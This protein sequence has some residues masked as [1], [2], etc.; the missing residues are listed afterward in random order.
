VKRRGE[1]LPT[2]HLKAGEIY[3]TDQP[4]VVVTV[5]G[6]CLSVVLH[7]S[8]LGIGGI[9]H[10]V[11]PSCPNKKKCAEGCPKK[12]TYVDCSIRQMTKLFESFGSDRSEIKAKCFGGA[13]LF[14]RPIE[15]PGLL[16]VGRQ[17]SKIAE[18]TIKSEGL[19]L[20]KRDVGGQ[21]GRKILFYTHTGEVL[22]KRLKNANRCD[23]RG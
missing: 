5:L 15:K 18:E 22:L 14:S 13:D 19:R 2:V 4:T 11:L 17:N 21:Q 12:F 10:G 3:C 9:C 7:H 23:V 8:R 20:V 6:S 16:S 1:E